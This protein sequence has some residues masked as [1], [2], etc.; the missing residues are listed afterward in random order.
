MLNEKDLVEKT[1][2]GDIASF[3]GLY[4]LYFDRI[5]RYIFVRIWNK[6]EA[7][8]L[9]EQVFL[10][11]IESISSFKWKGNHFSSWLFKIAH[12]LLIDYHR[13]KS[14]KQ[15]LQLEESVVSSGPDPEFMAELNISMSQLSAA[16]LKLT[17]L[18]RQVIS[19]RFAGGLSI[20]ETATVMGKK[21]NAVK[22]LQH[23]AVEALRRY[24]T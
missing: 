8:D 4:E 20:T 3:A 14:R 19:L 12:N 2:K 24:L 10:Q 17:Y 23:S 18:Q 16:I 5:Y 9:T 6:Y 11:A 15:E 1:V 22:A 7:E 21:E 13:K